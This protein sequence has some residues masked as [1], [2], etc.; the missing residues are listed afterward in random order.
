MAKKKL[1]PTWLKVTALAAL[2]VPYKFEVD[3]DEDEKLKKLTVRSVA[4]HLTYKAGKPG[5]KGDLFVVV[6]GVVAD[7]CKVKYNGVPVTADGEVIEE[8]AV[9][10]D[11]AET[12]S[13]IEK[14]YLQQD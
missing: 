1:V 11:E 13:D 4:A 14:E 5:E 9:P 3:R 2:F 8:D 7:K 6:P 10:F 12:L